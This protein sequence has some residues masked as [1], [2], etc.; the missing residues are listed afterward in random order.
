MG[1]PPL[2]HALILLVPAALSA[3][4]CAA[5]K[6]PA[7]AD[8]ATSVSEAEARGHG[9]PAATAQ[10]VPGQYPAPTYSAPPPGPALPDFAEPPAADLPGLQ[11]QLD[12]FEQALGLVLPESTGQDAAKPASVPRPQATAATP[13]AQ[14]DPCLVACAALAS[15]KRSADHLCG[16]TG[17]E[18]AACGGARERVQRAEQRVTRACP[19]CAGK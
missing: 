19:A 10:P 1:M 17:E 11:A 15:M 2:R 16:M 4:A 3:I 6:A 8:P 14:A 12:R 13:V 18:D 5:A 7:P 9:Q